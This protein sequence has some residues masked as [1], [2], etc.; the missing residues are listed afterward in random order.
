MSLGAAVKSGMLAATAHSKHSICL[1]PEL[2]V[3]V[4]FRIFFVDPLVV[5]VIPSVS[6]T[7]F[8]RI[9][10]DSKKGNPGITLV[11]SPIRFFLSQ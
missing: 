7:R 4:T 11:K 9:H 1:N 5:H 8:Q 10:A 3:T 6:E 2:L